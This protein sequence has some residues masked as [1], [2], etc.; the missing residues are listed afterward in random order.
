MGYWFSPVGLRVAQKTV[1]R[2]VEKVARLYEQG[3]D[4]G[5]IELYLFHW[6]RWA[7]AGLGSLMVAGEGLSWG[8]WALNPAGL[9]E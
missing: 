6:G 4:K 1:A 3:E 5:R 8:M 9:W 7:R 2:M